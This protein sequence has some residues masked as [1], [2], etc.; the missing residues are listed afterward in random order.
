MEITWDDHKAE[1]NFKKH[2]VT[3][4]EAATVILSLLSWVAP[5]K[6]FSDDRWEYL[7]Y[8]VK[9]RVLYVVTVEGNDDIIRIISARKAE[10]Y[11]KERYEKGI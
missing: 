3:F 4:E 5:N 1:A 9:S 11:E 10:P 6:H 2:G 8:S 7:G